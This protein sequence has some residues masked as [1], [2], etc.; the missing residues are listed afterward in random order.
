MSK[1]DELKQM[2]LYQKAEQI[3]KIT[4]GLVEIV[5]KENEF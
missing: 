1:R 2:P 3:L 5:P 4:M